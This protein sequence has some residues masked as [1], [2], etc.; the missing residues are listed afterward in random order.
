MKARLLLVPALFAA[1][2]GLAATSA[3]SVVLPERVLPALEPI[4]R[5]T[6]QQSPRM[7]SRALDLEIAENNRIQARAGLLPG[8]GASFRFFETKDD[9]A[10]VGA[11]R[12]QKTYYD[13]SVNQ[14]LFHWGERVNTKRIGEIQKLIA[15]GSYREAYRQT[16]QEVRGKYV[17][18][19]IQKQQLR[20][21]R[22]GL[23][24]ALQQVKFGEERLAKKVISDAEMHPL[25]VAAEQGQILLERTEWEYEQGRRSFARLAGLPEFTDADVPDDIPMV[26]YDAQTFERLLAEFL[27]LRELPT[28]EAATA[29]RQVEVSELALK[30]EKTRLRP[31]VSLLAGTNQDEQAYTINTAQ[32]YRVTSY[33][34]GVSVSWTLFDGFTSQTATRN[35]IARLRQSRIDSEEATYRLAQQAQN[36]AKLVNF[37]ARA[38]AI[39]DRSLSSAEG[40]VKAKIADFKRGTATEADVTLAN[41]QVL[42]S[43]IT[44]FASRQEYLWRVGDFLG[45][46][47]ADPAVAQLPAK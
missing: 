32:K 37:A 22:E 1:V 30:N 29:R 43:R 2:A 35:A 11:T 41:L 21:A 6:A 23:A 4:L 18:L 40:A 16:V 24:F 10:D 33:Y 36:Q 44:A 25:R 46:L 7:I 19:I 5:Q 28:Y 20:R 26:G 15:E 34:A 39:A 12:A 14:A 31:K 42:D 17:L 8:I 47:A 27:S 9:R 45:T 13:V 38:M 3:E